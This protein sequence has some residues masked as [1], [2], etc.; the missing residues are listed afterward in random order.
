MSVTRAQ[1]IKSLGAT[2]GNAALGTG[3]ALAAKVLGSNIAT[4]LTLPAAAQVETPALPFLESGP[5]EANRI[6][7]TF[8]DGPTPG[9]TELILDRLKERGLAASFFMIGQN[10]TVAPDLVKRV[11]AEGHAVGNHTYT[12]PKL[13]DLPDAQVEFELARTQDTLAEILNHRPAMFRPP[14][15]FFRKNQGPLARKLGLRVVLWS[16]DSRDWAQ[17]GEDK[18][19][20]M[21]LTQTKAGSIILC[22][23]LHRQTVDCISRVLDQ[24]LEREFQFVPVTAFMEVAA[25]SLPANA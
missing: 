4:R 15:G 7:L 11:F 2:A 3:M 25:Q 17:P 14:Y 13:S 6:A 22:H 24:L 8:D 21:I 16:V 18:I 9:L 19:A 1:F 12:H 5:P 23:E 10:A 20:E